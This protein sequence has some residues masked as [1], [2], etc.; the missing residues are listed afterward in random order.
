MEQPPSNS[1]LNKETQKEQD[2]TQS[3]YV[4]EMSSA[5]YMMP[6]PFAHT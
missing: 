1:S 2:K 6:P 3:Q 5:M 4:S